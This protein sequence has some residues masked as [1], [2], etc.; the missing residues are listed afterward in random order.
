MISIYTSN[1]SIYR[2]IETIAIHVVNKYTIADF[3]IVTYYHDKVT[4]A[5]HR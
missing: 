3:T 5:M 2:A 1:I 4:I